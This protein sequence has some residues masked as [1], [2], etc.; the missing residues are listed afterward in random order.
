MLPELAQECAVSKVVYNK[1]AIIC[2]CRVSCTISFIRN[3]DMVQYCEGLFSVQSRIT[4]VISMSKYEQ[5][6]P[7]VSYSY[8]FNTAL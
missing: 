8:T 6:H 4:Y 5:T 3:V 1:G 2:P 7:V